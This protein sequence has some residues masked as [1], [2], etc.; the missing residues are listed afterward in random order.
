MMGWNWDGGTWLTMGWGMLIWLVVGVIVIWLIVR[1]LTGL[2]RP[3]E[4]RSEDLLEFLDR[5]PIR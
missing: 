2:P 5:H 1:G 4:T 3:V